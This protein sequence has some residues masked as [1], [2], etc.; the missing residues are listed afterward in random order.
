ML[1]LDKILKLLFPYRRE[2]EEHESVNIKIIIGETLVL[3]VVLYAIGFAINRDDPLFLKN[4]YGFAIS[5]IPLA[6]FTLFYGF[7]S[8]AIYLVSYTLSAFLVYGK[9]ENFQNIVIMTFYLLLFAEFHF[10]WNKKIQTYKEKF[11]YINEKLRDVARVLYVTKIS[12][13]R[14][15]SYHL[16]KPVSIRGVLE[17]LSKDMLSGLGLDGALRRAVMLISNLYMIERAGLYRYDGRKF[18]EVAKLGEF[19]G[20]DPEDPLVRYT[21]EKEQPSFVPAEVVN[22]DT[23]YVCAI[24]IY[25]EQKLE[26]IFLIESMP[27]LNINTE[28]I[29]S[30]SMFLY[31]VRLEYASISELKPL[32]EKFKDVEFNLLKEVNRALSLRERYGVNSSVV[33]YVFENYNER[34]YSFFSESVRAL[35]TV[36][37]YGQNCLLI[38]LPLT[39]IDGANAFIKRIGEK[40]QQEAP[41][42]FGKHNVYT[43]KI[44]DFDTLISSVEGDA[45]FRKAEEK[46]SYREKIAKLKEATEKVEKEKV[47]GEVKRTVSKKKKEVQELEEQIHEEQSVE[48]L[49]SRVV[50][51]KGVEELETP[52]E[53]PKR[54][55]KGKAVEKEVQKGPEPPSGP[56]VIRFPKLPEELDGVARRRTSEDTL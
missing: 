15:E 46:L 37:R 35:D 20:F 36:S 17:E 24:P 7:V 10:Y 16:S 56:K 55:K 52:K 34:L 49:K 27:F 50:G 13:D 6:L 1:D 9:I 4:T 38:L 18:V 25:E 48:T 28:N 42:S 30:I 45:L 39:N 19:S 26:Y 21:L 40:A 54:R 11:D 14:L 29:L 8:G 41:L 47:R 2:E 33:A 23:K 5:T 12:H 22:E 44:E 51:A 32:V 3:M 53:K 31:Y 43:A